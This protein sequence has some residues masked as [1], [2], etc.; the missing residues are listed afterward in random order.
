MKKEIKKEII[1]INHLKSASMEVII[2]DHNKSASNIHTKSASKSEIMDRLGEITEIN[3]C[4]MG[5]N[6]GKTDGYVEITDRLG[7][8]TEINAC[9]MDIN[10]RKTNINAGITDIFAG[11]TELKYPARELFW[12]M[13]RT[14]RTG[15]TGL[16]NTFI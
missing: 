9:T 2:M 15:K 11:R 3:A 7:E 8:I 5:I 13:C 1:I 16:V 12:K 6:A 10:A 4:T 14:L